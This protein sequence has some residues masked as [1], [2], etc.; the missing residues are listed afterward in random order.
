M[1]V[2]GK[3]LHILGMIKVTIQLGLTSVFKRF[4]PVV[5]ATYLQG[6]LLLGSDILGEAPLLW[7]KP[8]GIITFNGELIPSGCHLIKPQHEWCRGISK[9]HV[10]KD[11]DVRFALF[12]TRNTY[13]KPYATRVLRVNINRPPDTTLVIY[14]RVGA[15]L[16]PICV[17]VDKRGRVPCPV[18][19]DTEHPLRLGR[20]MVIGR[21]G[22]SVT[23]ISRITEDTLT[24]H[25]TND[26]VPPP[27]V[28]D[29]GHSRKETLEAIMSSADWSHLGIKQ[30]NQLRTLL[31][32]F[33]D[34][35]I[36]EEG[37]LGR[38][39]G[40][41]V[42]I[43]IANHTPA[44]GR[45]FR[46]PEKAKV[47]IAELL[48]DMHAKDIIEPSTA[49][50]LS[51]I[52]LVSKPDG[53]KRMCLDYR[54]VNTHL[55]EDIHPLP[56]L[57]ELV[58]AAAGYKYYATLDMREA[59]FQLV[60]DEDSR[61][62][63][64]FSDGVSLYR[65][66]R[67]PFGLQCSPAIFSRKMEEIIAPLSALG[68]VRNYLDDIILWADSFDCLLQRLQQVLT[69]LQTRGVKLNLK[70]CY[71]GKPEVK[72]LGHIVS[73]QGARPD[74]GNV[75]AVLR[76]KPP[77]TVKGVRSFLGLCGFYRR[78]IKN[79][80]EVALPLTNLTRKDID[81]SWSDECQQAFD[82]LKTLLTSAPVLAK[83][84][85]SLPFVL[86]TDASDKSVG[87]VLSQVMDGESR[88]IGFFSRKLNPAETRYSVT[89][90][91]ALGVILACRHFYH[92]LWGNKFKV[93]TDHQP[94]THIFTRKTKSPRMTRW[95]LEMRDFW[96]SIHYVKGK[97][98]VVADDLSRPVLQVKLNVRHPTETFLGL[99]AQQLIQSQ[100]QDPK[101][102]ETIRFCLGLP[103]TKLHKRHRNLLKFTLIDGI[104]FFSRDVLGG[105]INW[106]LV[107]P[108]DL[109][110]K[111]LETAHLGVGHL[112]QKKTLLKCEEYFF[113]ENLRG[114]CYEY[115]RGCRRC[116]TF[117]GS[118]GLVQLWQEVPQ[119]TRPMERVSL[120]LVDMVGGTNNYRYVLTTIDNY[121]RFVRF[122]PLKSKSTLEVTTAFSFYLRSY[123]IPETVLTDNGCEFT[124]S[125][126]QQKCTTAGIVHVT[127]APYNPR[128][129]GMIER[130]HSSMK[131]ILAA[132]CEGRPNSWPSM[133]DT[134]ENA[135]NN[136]VHNSTNAQPFFAFFGRHAPRRLSTPLPTVPGI[137][138][139]MQLARDIIIK[140]SREQARLYLREKNA[141][142]KNEVAPLHTLV[143]VKREV[144]TPGTSRKLNTKWLG[145]FKVVEVLRG[146]SAYI[147]EDLQRPGRRIHRAA[148]KVKK[149]VGDG[150]FLI[151]DVDNEEDEIDE[152]PKA[153]LA[154]QRLPPIRYRED[155]V[156]PALPL[157]NGEGEMADAA[158]STP[159]VVQ[160]DDDETSTPATV[161]PSLADAEVATPSAVPSASTDAEVPIPPAVTTESA[162]AEV[163]IPSAVPS[164]SANAEVATPSAVPTTSGTVETRPQRVRRAP[165]RLLTEL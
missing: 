68:W 39:T 129:N 25:I 65:F 160:P 77:T 151:G 153:R 46:Y 41:E 28:M 50:W 146:G 32:N 76:K 27:V 101:W 16:F 24:T 44:K 162:D 21:F 154:R 91:E 84:R 112:G 40:P 98:N 35:F 72:F 74:P 70:K 15:S 4:I 43:Q 55:A 20:G 60:L 102:K 125:I 51:P 23:A 75:E 18:V 89:D 135:I 114:D 49:A 92:F 53:S 81:F 37:E 88:V 130:M 69:A 120:D 137:Q 58:E 36:L 5:P 34:L 123:G 131:M 143:W 79:F 83:P 12:T 144:T 94:L 121:S 82:N 1:G 80:T 150:E 126:F 93:F 122:F 133:L 158:D 163:S 164:S 61:D 96:Y 105:D 11:N 29:K 67:L 54:L 17:T 113:W 108:E 95:A 66:K 132:L 3:N 104:L 71:L 56:R 59:Y 6:D 97:D 127:T 110:S 140:T 149:C 33:T 13:L 99:T 30:R 7:D 156:R 48:K 138:S 109:K 142:R 22:P 155:P 78:H 19:N 73:E 148:E 47:I 106:V 85:L 116:Q 86:T 63:T 124:S 57:E 10:T 31:R 42:H 136:A 26:L 152:I 103:T 38:I 145:P 87:A 90:K 128:G 115:V 9:R 139:D 8:R 134:C 147:L 2:T 161:T 14:P 117:K 107:V 118:K 165:K 141:H 52:V 111:A 159:Q 119:V 45:S 64:T 62:L 157:Y 100:R